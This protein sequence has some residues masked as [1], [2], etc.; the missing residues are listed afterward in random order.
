MSFKA[1]KAKKMPTLACIGTVDGIEEMKTTESYDDTGVTYLSLP[2][3]IKPE[4]AGRATKAY[5][6]FRPEWLVPGFDPE[7]LLQYEG[8]QAM[9]KT[10]RKNIYAQGE[11]STLAGLAGSDERF[12]EL[13]TLIQSLPVVASGADPNLV[14]ID[15]NEVVRVVTSF[16]MNEK[17]MIGYVLKQGVKRV[18]LNEM[19]ESGRPKIEWE[20][21]QYY[22]VDSWFYPTMEEL[23]RKRDWAE[24]MAARAEKEGKEITYRV[25]WDEGTP[26]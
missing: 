14:I 9:Y 18:E 15:P 10:Y 4:A 24:K 6:K 17:S 11:I 1:A 8:G 25:T 21:T 13:A 7:S 2:I 16:L 12:E 19:D 3:Q 5:L 26:F 20:P 23:A 22:N